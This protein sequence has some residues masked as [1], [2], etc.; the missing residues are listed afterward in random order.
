MKQVITLAE[1]AATG[2]KWA[3]IQVNETF[4]WDIRTIRKAGQIDCIYMVNLH[5]PTNCCELAI[6]YPALSLKN[7]FHNTEGFT[8]DELWRL[9]MEG[10]C[11]EWN[12]FKET[13]KYQLVKYH[14]EGTE[15][16]ILEMEA[17]NPSVC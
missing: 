7:F 16:E 1:M 6:S 13:N 3:I 12:Y 17:A 5:E 8:E 9:E 14:A 10:T 4:Y 11:N 2:N 15:E